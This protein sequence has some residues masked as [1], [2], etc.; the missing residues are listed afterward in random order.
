MSLGPKRDALLKTVEQLVERY[1]DLRE[2][3]RVREEVAND[4]SWDTKGQSCG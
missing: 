3:T 2:S 4:Q 1:H